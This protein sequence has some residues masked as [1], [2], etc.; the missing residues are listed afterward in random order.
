MAEILEIANRSNILLIFSK[1]VKISNYVSL[2]YN[3]L[4]KKT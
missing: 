3:L 2:N 4:Q 1:D